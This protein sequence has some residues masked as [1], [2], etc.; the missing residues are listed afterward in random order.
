MHYLGCETIKTSH[1][2]IR[3]TQLQ[4]RI[5]VTGWEKKTKKQNG[6]FLQL[7][8]WNFTDATHQHFVFHHHL[9]FGQLVCIQPTMP[10]FFFLW[11]VSNVFAQDNWDIYSFHINST[12]TSRYATTI[13]TSRV[14]NRMDESKE[15]EFN[16]RIPKNAFISKFK[17]WV[18]QKWSVSIYRNT[19]K[20]PE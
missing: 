17:M 4:C 18:M 13:I 6:V 2:H 1:S 7:N 16:V 8:Q 19:L 14:A 10:I 3:G 12:V 9:I 20:N 5:R 15:I 11:N